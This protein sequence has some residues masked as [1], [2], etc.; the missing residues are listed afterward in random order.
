[1]QI[2]THP[3][4]QSESHAHVYLPHSP[5]SK[6]RSLRRTYHFSSRIFACGNRLESFQA[7]ETKVGHHSKFSAILRGNQYRG[8]C[9]FASHRFQYQYLSAVQ[10]NRRIEDHTAIHRTFY[11]GDSS[12][13]RERP[14]LSKKSSFLTSPLSFL[15]HFNSHYICQSPLF[16]SPIICP[17]C[18]LCLLQIIHYNTIVRSVI[19]SYRVIKKDMLN[20]NF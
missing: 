11:E 8:G 15:T 20:L 17:S 19:L 5:A 1:M 3:L 16:R 4:D 14:C 18:L 12:E 9:A 13:K 6:P 7:L 2:S 10:C